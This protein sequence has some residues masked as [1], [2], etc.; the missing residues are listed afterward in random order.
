MIPSG[1]LIA[2]E[3]GTFVVDLPRKDGGFPYH[4]IAMLVCQRA[5]YCGLRWILHINGDNE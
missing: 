3:N 1:N 4:H 5:I 2:I